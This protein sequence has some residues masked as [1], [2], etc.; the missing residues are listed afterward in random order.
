[1]SWKVTALAGVSAMIMAGQYGAQENAGEDRGIRKG[2]S[3]VASDLRA[4]RVGVEAY[5]IDHNH[6]P[7]STNITG[8]KSIET[9]VPTFSD[10]TFNPRG[11]GESGLMSLTTPIAYLSRLPLDVF[12][13]EAGSRYG[14]FTTGTAYLIWSAG[15]DRKYDLDISQFD[16]D[17][18]RQSAEFFARFTYDPTNGLVSSGDI[19]VSGSES[20]PASGR[21]SS[22]DNWVSELGAGKEQEAK[23]KRKSVFDLLAS[24]E[25][26]AQV[27][28]PE[29]QMDRIQRDMR[30]ISR[31]LETY[32]IDYNAYP[33][34]TTNTEMQAGGRALPQGV[35]TFHRG[36]PQGNSAGT[37]TGG[38][39]RDHSFLASLTTPIAY[40]TKMKEDP[41]GERSSSYAYYHDGNEWVV[42]SPGPD[43]KY[44]VD[45]EQ[46]KTLPAGDFL[47][48][49]SYD[50]SNGTVSRGDIIS[51]KHHLFG[52][53]EVVPTSV[54]H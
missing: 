22:G 6:Y 49:F 15:P 34:F 31:A 14:Y 24:A 52:E 51:H 18:E 11:S 21:V 46:F 8:Q 4:L 47:A 29:L 30:A 25:K 20:D 54:N 2:L 39:R 3:K 28:V 7:P 9:G 37:G 41:F 38:R 45:L 16:P 40:L 17:Q 12:A 36:L 27:E 13:P 43:G 26:V 42:W 33:V 53:G 19:W 23:P 1:M 44:D 32:R 10:S 5:R 35:P 48:K 50:P